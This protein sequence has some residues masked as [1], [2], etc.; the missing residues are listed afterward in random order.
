MLSVKYMLIKKDLCKVE[1]IEI[2]I[3]K[4]DVSMYFNLICES[5]DILV[6]WEIVLFY[7]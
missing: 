6:Y 5:N 4:K 7:K 3:K 1:I 2:N